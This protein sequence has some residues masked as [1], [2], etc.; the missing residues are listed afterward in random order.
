MDCQV[1]QE[2]ANLVAHCEETFLE[3][4][5]DPKHWGLE[6]V[7]MV[8][9]DGL[10]GAILWPFAKRYWQRHHDHRTCDPKEA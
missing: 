10:V 3:L 5:T 9:F 4:L 8:V 7:I 2:G 1:V 6:I